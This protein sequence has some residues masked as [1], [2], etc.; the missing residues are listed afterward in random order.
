MDG[1]KR[2]QC[3]HICIEENGNSVNLLHVF[4]QWPRD[5]Y[6]S[7]QGQRLG[8]YISGATQL[9]LD[10]LKIVDVHRRL[11]VDRPANSHR[12]LAEVDAV[13]LALYLLVHSYGEGIVERL[14]TD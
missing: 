1:E 2:R 6:I 11:V 7:V 4:E 3:Q 13:E 5:G 8:E 12:V 9:P 10:V 14:L